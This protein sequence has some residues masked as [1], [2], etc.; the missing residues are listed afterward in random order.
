MLPKFLQRYITNMRRNNENK[1]STT[2]LFNGDCEICSKEICV[3]QSYG[4]SQELQ[5]DFRDINV[6]D[7][8]ALGLT[9]DETARQLHVIKNSELFVGVK[10]FIVLWNEMPKYRF[11]A[12]I[13]SLPG[14]ERLAQFFYYHVI[15][16]Y[17]YKRDSKR[18]KS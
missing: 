12:K 7:L 3:Y 5:I 14:M 6:T 13:F 2:V 1:L 17:L 10:A 18:V 4:A 9:R 15:S 11:L 8:N 16:L